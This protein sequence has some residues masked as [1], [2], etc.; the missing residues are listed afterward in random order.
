MSC[1]YVRVNVVLR[2]YQ[3]FRQSRTTPRSDRHF[4]L[5]PDIHLDTTIHVFGDGKVIFTFCREIR[6]AE[7]NNIPTSALSCVPLVF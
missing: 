1:V 3:M 4:I 5:Y 2:V 6:E 7:T